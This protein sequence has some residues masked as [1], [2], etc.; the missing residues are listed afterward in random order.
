MGRIAGR[1]EGPANTGTISNI[2]FG[3]LVFYGWFLL[4]NIITTEVRG[5]AVQIRQPPLIKSKS[6]QK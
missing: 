6:K 1:G 5:G 3:E 4:R 2:G